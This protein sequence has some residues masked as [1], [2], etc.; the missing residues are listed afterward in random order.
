MIHLKI[1]GGI[2]HFNI[3]KLLKKEFSILKKYNIQI[4]VYDGTDLCPWNSGRPN[5]NIY[6]T[7]EKLN[8]FNDNNIGVFLTFSNQYIDINNKIGNKLLKLLNNN[9]LNGVI[10]RNMD[11]YNHIK[12]NYNLKITNSFLSQPNDILKLEEYNLNNEHLFDSLVPRFELL[13]NKSFLKKGDLSKYEI[14]SNDQP[15]V[16]GCNIFNKHSEYIDK[17]VQ[18]IE[19]NNGCSLACTFK[20]TKEY[21]DY[22]NVSDKYKKLETQF[23]IETYTNLINLGYR[24]F[25]LVGREWESME[26]YKN[27]ILNINIIKRM[28]NEKRII[29]I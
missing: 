21:L 18:N 3:F 9:S 22:I 1:A 25:K 11:L 13:Y 17:Y 23:D 12:N 2:K 7:N 29:N 10:V 24:R 20:Q 4:S 19:C 15:C 6:L 28:I 5:E 26:L 14:I 8:F 27:I 16:Y